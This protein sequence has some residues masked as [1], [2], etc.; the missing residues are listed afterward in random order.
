VDGSGVESITIRDEGWIWGRPTWSP[1]GRRI[2]FSKCRSGYCNIFIVNPDGTGLVQLTTVGNAEGPAWSPD[3]T[4]IAFT[5][6][7]STG[8]RSVAYV[9]VN[10]GGDPKVIF[11]PGHSPAWRP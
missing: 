3:G 7:S 9:A 2:A 4:R 1:G 5:L 8:E 10:S 6:W 11:S